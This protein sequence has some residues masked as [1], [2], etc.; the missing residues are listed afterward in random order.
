MVFI[1]TNMG[2]NYYARIIPNEDKK[3]ELINAI[4]KDDFDK[5]L[6]LSNELYGSRNE[7]ISIFPNILSFSAQ[8]PAHFAAIW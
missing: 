7:S 4:V 3:Q 8:V 6:E 1:F 2:T 5:V